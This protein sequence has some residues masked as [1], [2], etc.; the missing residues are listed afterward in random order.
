MLRILVSL[1]NF[2]NSESIPTFFAAS[3]SI[4]IAF[5]AF[6]TVLGFDLIYFVMSSSS[7]FVRLLLEMSG[8]HIVLPI[9]FLVVLGMMVL[10]TTICCLCMFLWV[11]LYCKDQLDC[12]V[13]LQKVF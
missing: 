3:E 5:K 10:L 9:R 12:L 4:G 1:L 6:M 13:P 11:L 2:S 8:K 7:V